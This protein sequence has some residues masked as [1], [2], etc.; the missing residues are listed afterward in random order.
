MSTPSSPTKNKSTVSN[1]RKRAFPAAPIKS[2]PNSVAYSRNVTGKKQ[3]G[4]ANSKQSKSLD[5]MGSY[6]QIAK[7]KRETSSLES[8]QMLL[9][10]QL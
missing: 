4:N 9:P 1:S 10:R 6:F 2:P 8:G 7:R 5:Q 3:P